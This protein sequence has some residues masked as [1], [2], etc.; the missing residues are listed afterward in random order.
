MNGNDVVLAVA[1]VAAAVFGL[2]LLVF[3]F[4]LRLWVQALLTNT[5][6]SI[7]G[8]IGM[9]LRGTPPKLILHAAIALRQRGE[10]VTVDEVE[11]CYLAHGI[12]SGMSATELADL[13]QEKRARPAG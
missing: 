1:A 10:M 9:R 8:I 13:V 11:R 2:F 7:F 6:V 5:P 4:T 3:F 12:G